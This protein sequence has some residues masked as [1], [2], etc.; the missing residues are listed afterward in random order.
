[1]QEL[2]VSSAVLSVPN[3]HYTICVVT[4]SSACAIGVAMYQVVANKIKYT[5]FITRSLSPSEQKW[6]SSKRELAAVNH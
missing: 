5:G 3:L 4:D 6:G 2:L 1:M